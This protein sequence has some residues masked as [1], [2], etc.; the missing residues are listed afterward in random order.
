MSEKP[1]KS[2]YKN[3][4]EAE[5][6]ATEFGIYVIQIGGDFF[7]SE[8]GKMGFS[9]ERAEMYF[10]TVVNGLNTL[11]LNGTDQEIADATVCLCNIRIMPLRIH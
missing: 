5:I 3:Y 1:T 8:S 11:I 9:K 7:T 4:S 10:D 6:A 2:A